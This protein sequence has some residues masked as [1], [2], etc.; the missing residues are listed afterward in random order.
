MVSTP[1]AWG[2]REGKSLCIIEL[3]LAP[4]IAY[5]AYPLDEVL[6]MCIDF[7]SQS[8][9]KKLRR[10]DP[11]S[12]PPE[13]LAD[14]RTFREYFKG[15]REGAERNPRF[16]TVEVIPPTTLFTDCK[17]PGIRINLGLPSEIS[18]EVRNQFEQMW[19]ELVADIRQCGVCP[20]LDLYRRPV[21]FGI[22]AVKAEYPLDRWGPLLMGG[23]I[24][25]NN[26]QQ[27][28]VS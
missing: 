16:L 18:V 26:P 11:Q 25:V 17:H 2:P 13:S 15:Q 14:F 28:F 24:C 10:L 19:Q 3:D 1:L 23:L 12:A 7:C 5:T 4:D 6:R 20:F 27:R 8:V 9:L 21:V 22:S